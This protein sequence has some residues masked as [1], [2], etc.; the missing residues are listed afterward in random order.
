MKRFLKVL[1]G[2]ILL[3]IP[4]LGGVLWGMQGLCVGLLLMATC[5]WVTEWV[6]VVVT[7]LLVVLGLSVGATLLSPTDAGLYIK[8]LGNPILTLFFGGFVMAGAIQR[9]KLDRMMA[10]GLLRLVPPNPR[11]VLAAIIMASV[12]VSMWISNTAATLMMLPIV[13]SMADTLPKSDRFR[14]AMLLAVPFAANVGGMATPVGTPPNAIALGWLHRAGIDMTFG[15][16]MMWGMPVAI[17]GGLVIWMVLSLLFR[18]KER[19]YIQ[20]ES[21][22]VTPQAWVTLGI[23]VLAIG[24]WITGGWHGMS[25]STVALGAA[26]CLLAT[27][28]YLPSDLGKLEWP[29]MLL[30]WGGLALGLAIEKTGVSMLV[31]DWLAGIPSSYSTWVAMGVSA[32]LSAVMNDTATANVVI[33]II[34]QIPS[35]HLALTIFMTAVSSSAAMVLPVSCAPNAVLFGKALVS[36][37]TFIMVGSLVTLGVLA[38]IAGWGLVVASIW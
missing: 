11:W 25:D 38:V 13:V 3:G 33:P 37:R 24:L 4:V 5:M 26:V 28:A 18:T 15:A 10:H 32:T 21:M 27:G 20:T 35:N 23:V 14:V 34:G 8:E 36:S 16:W 1:T 2:G 22:D 9:A 12:G 6:P 30:M 29:V 7:S 17:L 19:I 31:G